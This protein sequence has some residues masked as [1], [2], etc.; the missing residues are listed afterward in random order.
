[1]LYR[2]ILTILFSVFLIS[3]NDDGAIYN[4]SGTPTGTNPGD[5]T[6]TTDFSNIFLKSHIPLSIPDGAGSTLTAVYQRFDMGKDDTSISYVIKTSDNVYRIYTPTASGDVEI[7]STTDSISTTTAGDGQKLLSW[8]GKRDIVDYATGDTLAIGTALGTELPHSITDSGDIVVF[9]SRDDLAGANSAGVNQ[10]FTLSTDGSEIY[11]QVT[12]F[13][14]DFPIEQPII[15]GGGN[16]IFFSSTADVME[17]GSNADGASELFSIN[18]DGTGLIQHS[19][20]NAPGIYATGVSVDGIVASVEIL[21]LNGSNGKSLYTLNTVSSTFFEIAVRSSSSET[22]D[23]DLSSDG[24]M[25]TFQDVDGV[26]TP[27][28][29]VVNSNGTFKR[30]VF[31]HTGTIEHLQFNSNATQV[32]FHSNIDFGKGVTADDQASQI[33]TILVD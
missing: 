7:Y 13:T 30:S 6:Q 18:K 21:N 17:D 2:L 9:A 16:K 33:Y 23:H 12:S 3:C 22:I 27:N 25:I 15:S 14:T 32:T 5:G 26:G 20:L 24:T 28:I 1:M 10:L 29:Y 8:N 31:A 19:N 11:N 4:T